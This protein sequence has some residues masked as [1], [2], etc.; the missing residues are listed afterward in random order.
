MSRPST[1][2]ALDARRGP[3]SSMFPRSA[4]DIQRNVPV[5]LESWGEVG[6]LIDGAYR[7]GRYEGPA[8]GPDA[9]A[10]TGGP[11]RPREGE[12]HAGPRHP[13]GGQQPVPRGHPTGHEQPGGP[14]PQPV[15]GGDTQQPTGPGGDTS[16]VP[17][18]GSGQPGGTAPAPTPVG[19]P[20]GLEDIP[21]GEIEQLSDDEWRKLIEEELR[22]AGAELPTAAAP[23]KSEAK[24]AHFR[25]QSC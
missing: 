24:R 2:A 6:G 12:G 10:T 7:H 16:G 9:G 3:D 13:G 5:I 23:S 1:Q 20:P 4:G 15:P 18:G 25:C 8:E 21:T 22:N 17:G 11:R 14:G 19:P